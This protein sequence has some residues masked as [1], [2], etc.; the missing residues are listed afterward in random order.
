MSNAGKGT[1]ISAVVVLAAG[2][3]VGVFVGRSKEQPAPKTVT[4]AKTVEPTTTA[5]SETT[6]STTT[7]PTG[8]GVYMSDLLANETVTCGGDDAI[9]DPEYGDTLTVGRETFNYAIAFPI[10]LDDTGKD[11]GSCRV[12]PG[13]FKTFSS[14]V[15]F[16]TDSGES[17][18]YSATLTIRENTNRGKQLWSGKLT[19]SGSPKSFSFGLAGVNELYI[20]LTWPPTEFDTFFRTTL[21]FGDPTFQ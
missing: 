11:E 1:L 17:S 15:G 19:G 14:K 7:E 4:V 9:A 3:L 5:S 6:S 8:E 2:A 13:D 21:V 12:P 10:L 18:D 16:L 20:V